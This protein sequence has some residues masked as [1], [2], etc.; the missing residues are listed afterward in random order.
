LV[1]EAPRSFGGKED[2]GSRI[3]SEENQITMPETFWEEAYRGFQPFNVTDFLKHYQDS[4]SF[5]FFFTLLQKVT[6]KAV[7]DL[8]CGNGFLS[9]LLA[10]RGARVT[11]VDTSL[12]AIKSTQLLA[13]YNKVSDRVEALPFNVFDIDKLPQQFDIITGNY[14]LH[15]IEPFELL[16]ERMYTALKQGGKGIFLENNGRNIFLML[17]RKYLAG[18]FGIPKFG[19][20]VERP[21]DKMEVE[22]IK[23]IFP[24]VS[25]YYMEFLFFKLLR[26]YMRLE[27]R[28]IIN[29]LDKLDSFIY[30]HFPI[31]R[32]F[33]YRQVIVFE[34]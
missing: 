5:Q 3:R 20:E 17:S 29:L 18:R 30:N 7:L 34:K 33:S 10:T 2:Q 8:G 19:D 25:I 14:I 9:V 26:L 28:M 12:T 15:H 22:I 16:A 4:P 1:K 23:K 32:K 6:D 24:I 27:N 13:H 21:F 11:A 31:L